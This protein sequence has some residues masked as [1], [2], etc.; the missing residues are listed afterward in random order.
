M[1]VKAANPLP[2]PPSG[3]SFGYATRAPVAHGGN[4]LGAS[5]S[6]WE[7]TALVHLL[8][9]PLQPQCAFLYGYSLPINI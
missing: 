2:F 1:L 6:P 8:P 4:P 5:L 3:E 7:K 9:A